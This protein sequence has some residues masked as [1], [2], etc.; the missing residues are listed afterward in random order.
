MN[1]NLDQRTL[2]MCLKEINNIGST[3][4]QNIC[5]GQSTVVP[6]GVG[7]WIGSII[8]LLLGVLFFSIIVVL[9]LI[10]VAATVS[11]LRHK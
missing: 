8:Q 9:I 11:E 3:T 1:I 7:N 10:G 4:Y 2:D 5:T 6:W